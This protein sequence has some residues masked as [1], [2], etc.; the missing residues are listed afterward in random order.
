VRLL[1]LAMILLTGAV[2]SAATAAQ[3]AAPARD[4]KKR[5]KVVKKRVHGHIK[6]VRVCTKPKPKPV[7]SVSLQLDT[8]HAVTKPIA[9]ADGGTLTATAGNGTKLT[10]TIP[11]DALTAD[12]TVT[13][14]PVT[15]LGGLPKGSKFLGGVQLSPDG[16][17]L[18]KDATLTIETNAPAK[19]LRAIGWTGAGKDPYTYKAKRVGGAIQVSVIHFSGTGAGDVTSHW[20]AVNALVD[21]YP[22]IHQELVNATTTDS[23]A[24]ARQAVGDWL[25]WERELQILQ[26]YVILDKRK[27]LREVLLPKVFKRMIEESSQRCK[28]R[29]DVADEVLFLTGLQRQVQLLGLG[30]LNAQIE[31]TRNQCAIFELDFESVITGI[32]SG[33]H[34]TAGVRVKALKLSAA[35]DFENE[36]PLEYQRFE[37]LP[38]A[39]GECVV[40]T[41]PR[42]DE[43]FRAKLSSV[44][45]GDD[46]PGVNV[47]DPHIVMH[48]FGGTTS[49]TVT[50]TCPN[51]APLTVTLSFW[52]GLFKAFHH[53]DSAPY[54]LLIDDWEYVGTSLFARKTYSQSVNTGD[55]TVT[56]Q[57]TLELRHTPE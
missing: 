53:N 35:N 33:G 49:E 20:D 40:V 56:E 4:A 16:T 3:D 24:I 6:K 52:G 12:L 48:V 30:A 46:P 9:A 13:V 39:Q 26:A 23:V 55:G 8:A 47:G 37:W 21:A 44:G 32:V 36:A 43:P 29:H 45:D 42:G 5:C 27:E 25:A 15:S 10:L 7:K 28:E 18:L 41:A 31:Q 17:G 38:E 14:T 19:N 34:A 1:A 22:R 57:T 51:S 50:V 54:S 2:G 11:K